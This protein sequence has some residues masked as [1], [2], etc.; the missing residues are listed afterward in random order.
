M[1]ILSILLVLWS[2]SIFAEEVHD[3]GFENLGIKQARYRQ[4]NGLNHRKWL[5]N[6]VEWWYNPANQPFTTEQ[7]VQAITHASEAW[8]HISG[9]HFAYKGLTT[10]NLSNTADGKLVIG[11]LDATTFTKRFGKYSGYSAIWWLDTIVDGEVSLNLGD[12][13]MTSLVN[14]FQAIMTHELGHTI[15]LDH[16]NDAGSIMSLPYHTYDY[17]MTLRTDDVN[18]ARNLYPCDSC[19]DF[20]RVLN[21]AESNYP[22][23]FKASHKQS[24]T[25]VPNSTRFYPETNTYLGY[26]FE[27]DFFYGINPAIWGEPMR[28]FGGLGDY[29]NLAVQAGF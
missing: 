20:Y 6:T 26:N 4:F 1:R 18:A 15:G 22:M 12:P 5:N 14:N 9:V 10:Q 24:K 21:W 28:K 29:L 23:L 16:S 11:W 3:H 2:C 7:A 25:L 19:G 13:R 17:Q 8:Q 27:D